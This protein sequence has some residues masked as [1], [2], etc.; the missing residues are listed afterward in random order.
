MA[1]NGAIPADPLKE[2]FTEEVMTDLGRRSRNAPA[3]RDRLN[4]LVARAPVV[5]AESRRIVAHP[6]ERR[7]RRAAWET[8]LEAAFAL[9]L[10]DPP[11]G[12][13]LRTRL[14]SVDE[15]TFR[16]A[17]AECLAG[18]VLAGKLDLELR[19]RPP[20]PRGP[21]EYLIEWG[22][23]GIYVEVKAPHREPLRRGV[24]SGDDSPLLAATLERANRQ[25][26]DDRAN[27]LVI[28]PTL[29]IP[30][31]SH[32][33]QLARAFYGQQVLTQPIDVS[34]GGAV[35]PVTIEFQ[36]DGS[37]LRSQKQD[38]SPAFTRVGGVLCIEEFLRHGNP[39]WIDHHILL[40]HNPNAKPGCRL[41][42][43]I[44]K[45]IPQLVEIDD[46][47]V[48]TDGAAAF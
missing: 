45:S 41:P 18:W 31:A 11:D 17:M 12:Q 44:W 34:R 21:G 29:R 1:R 39:P 47:M 22:D 20:G 26:A 43:G 33:G 27:L 35:G 3:L 38:G 2:V 37:F 7:A 48:W 24:I 28:A 46:R 36:P 9:G 14:T 6:P 25:F 42:T 40:A 13:H 8:Y 19:P 4:V 23:I 16:G 10:F 15:D 5:D 32:R 30:V